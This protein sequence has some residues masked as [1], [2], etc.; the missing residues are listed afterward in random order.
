MPAIV[1]LLQEERS[2][3]VQVMEEREQWDTKPMGKAKECTT[4][5]QEVAEEEEEEEGKKGARFFS[6]LTTEVRLVGSNDDKEEEEEFYG[7]NTHIDTHKI[8]SA[9]QSAEDDGEEK[10]KLGV[11]RT[12]IVR[13]RSERRSLKKQKKLQ[14]Q[15]RKLE[16]GQHEGMGPP[17]SSPPLG[18]SQRR[19]GRRF[20]MLLVLDLDGTLVHSEF[21]PRPHHEHDFSLF[22][23]EIFVYKR[24]FLDHFIATIL[25]WFDVAVWTASGGD[26]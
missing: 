13:R 21:R 22:N 15:M 18:S 4:S 14:K 7:D 6:K 24:P 3:E 23:Q 8:K 16:E 19:M 25:E 9:H 12:E 5:A 2:K 20:P 10:A 17:A 1:V 11:P 26:T